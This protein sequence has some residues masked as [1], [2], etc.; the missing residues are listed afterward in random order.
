MV[1]Y[2]LLL[3]KHFKPILEIL[4]MKNI[5]TLN[6]QGEAF[7]DN[8]D[9]EVITLTHGNDVFIAH[10]A[11]T[12]SGVSA[13][14]VTSCLADKATSDFDYSK[15]NITLKPCFA[16][17]DIVRSAVE[18]IYSRKP[19][20]VVTWHMEYDVNLLTCL[21]KNLHLTLGELL[22]GKDSGIE[23]TYYKDESTIPVHPAD[24]DI[25]L[26]SSDGMRY[27]NAINS[28]RKTPFGKKCDTYQLSHILDKS[29]ELPTIYSEEDEKPIGITAH[30]KQC[31]ENPVHYIAQAVADDIA[32]GRLTED[33]L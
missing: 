10:S 25:T 11:M 23:V 22:H 33:F 5:I 13:E 3:S 2:P 16:V 26:T 17:I 30:E 9:I 1:T 15:L 32:L 21:A 7:Y 28:Y 8:T 24:R 19:D 6:V 14:E 31:R 29:Y 20:T 18:W 12:Y 27:I 4:T